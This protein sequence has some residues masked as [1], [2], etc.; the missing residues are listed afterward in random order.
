MELDLGFRDVFSLGY[1]GSPTR[2]SYYYYD[3]NAVASVQG[4][5]LNPSVTN[6]IV[7]GNNGYG[8]YN[9][10]V[11]SLR[12]QMSHEFQAEVD[13]TWGKSLDTSSSPYETQYYPYNPR[14]SYGPS[15]Y[16][17]RSLVK[18][19]GMW[20]PVFF[21]GNHSWAKKVAGGW[22]LSGIFNWHTG[23]PWSPVFVV[24][25]GQLYCSTCSYTNRLP[26][27]Y[28]GG[29]GHDTSN[30]A[31]KSGPG[32]GNG[33]NVNFPLAATATGTAYFVPPAYTA[34]PAF[35]A[36]GRLVPQRPGIV[37]NSLPGPH[38][39]DLDFTASKTF[40]IP[41]LREGS[42]LQFRADA[43]NVFNNLNFAPGGSSSGGGISN[44]ITSTNFG[45][46]TSSL[47]ARTLS[48]QASLN[49]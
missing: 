39:R 7:F 25:S 15:D 17:V 3:E 45:Q 16:D 40:G 12:H 5:P 6:V 4:I 37:R 14:L 47:G 20:Q 43:F 19:F 34:G 49:F 38:Y 18:I 42:G 2:H 21:H 41:H 29:A 9:S 32:V 11:T 48:L 1:T 36:T 27:G 22:N 31:F 44:N 10:M 30:A 33:L 46:A 13:Y 28:L 8:T 35:P 26:G 23:F 24:P